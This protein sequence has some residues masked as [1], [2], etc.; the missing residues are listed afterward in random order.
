MVLNDGASLLTE[1]YTEIVSIQHWTELHPVSLPIQREFV[2]LKLELC[3]LL[4]DML[5]A[6]LEQVV[7]KNEI[8]FTKDSAI[9]VC[10]FFF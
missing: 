3:H 2:D 10:R 6:E 7:Y 1:I 4:A 9:K 8:D 5:E